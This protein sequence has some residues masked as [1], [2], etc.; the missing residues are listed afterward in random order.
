MQE[1]NGALITYVRPPALPETELIFARNDANYWRVF[2]E[3]YVVCTT[4][5]NAA[6]YWRYRGKIHF[7][8][9]HTHMFM[10]PG[11]MHVNT[12]VFKPADHK[13][14]QIAP[15]AVTRAAAELGLRGTPHFRAARA[16]DEPLYQALQRFYAAVETNETALE[17]QSR[18]TTCLRLL[19]EHHTER[20]P[21]SQ[22]A[23][24]AKHAVARAKAFLHERYNESVNLAEL[25]AVA[26]LSPF[27]LLR[28]FATQVGIP[29]H[30]YQI[31]LRVERART[32][33][34]AGVPPANAALFVGFADQS[35][36]TRHFRRTLHIT[37]SRYVR[38]G[39]R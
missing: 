14:L 31:R 15:A 36:L 34:R 17:Q 8:G 24:K 26:G 12:K 2:H 30:A 1:A 28:T 25:S 11:E 37:P 32:L 20:A 3:R 21:P 22:A 5:A 13:V 33:L 7:L 10:E 27:H 35:H 29:P 4:D 39:G 6:A 38:I 19:L 9:D 18:F 23:M 16:T